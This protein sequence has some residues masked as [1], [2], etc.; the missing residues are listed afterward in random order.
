MPA[1]GPHPSESWDA[2][3]DASADARYAAWFAA[4]CGTAL[5]AGTCNFFADAG[6]NAAW[7]QRLACP[8]ALGVACTYSATVPLIPSVGHVAADN[9]VAASCNLLSP[10]SAVN[11][12]LSPTGP[13]GSGGVR[14]SMPPTF[15]LA[16]RYQEHESFSNGDPPAAINPDAAFDFQTNPSAM[17]PGISAQGWQLQV[18]AGSR[19]VVRPHGSSTEITSS[20]SLTGTAGVALD[21]APSSWFTITALDV[22][23]TGSDT[24]D[25]GADAGGGT[26][27]RATLAM[28]TV[29][30]GSRSGSAIT[31]PAANAPA[32]VSVVRGNDEYDIAGIPSSNVTGTWDTSGTDPVLTIE[33]IYTESDTD[34]DLTL[35][36]QADPSPGAAIT[37][38]ATSPATYECTNGSATIT[39]SG[40]WTGPSTALDS[41]NLA[42]PT[43]ANLR[44]GSSPSY[45][46][47]IYPPTTPAATL[48]YYRNT[49]Y[50]WDV[51]RRLV[52][53]VDTQ[54]PT[55]VSKPAFTLGCS[56]GLPSTLL[57]QQLCTPANYPVTDACY[58]TIAGHPDAVT[59]RDATGATV[60]SFQCPPPP[61]Q[62]GPWSLPTP[63]STDPSL[64]YQVTW[65]GIDPWNNATPQWLARV[66]LAIDGS[67][68]GCTTNYT[69]NVDGY[70]PLS[71]A[72]AFTV[73]ALQR[74]GFEQLAAGSNALS[75]YPVSLAR[76]AGATVQ[77]GPD[78]M[79]TGIASNTARIFD[80]GSGRHGLRFEESRTNVI[81]DARNPAAASW[82][83]G[84]FV[85]TTTSYTSGPDGSTSGTYNDVSSGGY[86]RYYALG[87]RTGPYTGSVWVRQGALASVYR[88]DNNNWITAGNGTTVTGNTT[89][90]WQRVAATYTYANNAAGFVPNDARDTSA[91]G[92]GTAVALHVVTDLNQVEAGAFPTEVIVT[93]GGS[94]SRA[95]ERLA[96][97]AAA[98]S[99]IQSSKRFAFEV[100]LQPEGARSEYGSTP[101]RLWTLGASDYA[102]L[103]PASGVITV[104]SGGVSNTTSAGLNWNRNDEVE[105]YIA[106][107]GGTT[108][109]VMM[110]V[111]AG[112][113]WTATVTGSALTGSAP[114]TSMDLLCNGTSNQFSA[115]VRS[116]TAW[117]AGYKPAWVY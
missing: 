36:L 106:A 2:G 12:D 84:S 69:A 56:A 40:T 104:V 91:I 60:Q 113:P 14:G 26:Y 6:V 24:V 76:S 105:I 103:N 107:G 82:S 28:Q 72:P 81:A 110:R 39:P 100:R 48:S 62:G 67:H 46:L 9:V 31:I 109:S 41:W 1:W 35:V 108:T 43:G 55:A 34:Y 11:V 30:I 52:Q 87:T 63:V 89:S 97:T 93:S 111:N 29:W 10:A 74:A 21:P 61:T 45:T 4:T 75:G 50:T 47:P 65:R 114:A 38:P 73:K 96:T 98:S 59:I 83:A 112:A 64:T 37:T 79:V 53:T 78:T 19:L 20:T 57:F 44:A 116:V 3:T 49:S 15:C 90:S 94:A 25:A 95:G 8:K 85:T 70:W 117:S 58:G 71:S 17:D 22:H 32:W 115:A 18:A 88:V 5:P 54:P 7:S 66:S 51:R 23:S 80:G 102:E 13:Q 42:L 86:G 101:L 16:R 27:D 92:G 77:T 99:W 33:V 68:A